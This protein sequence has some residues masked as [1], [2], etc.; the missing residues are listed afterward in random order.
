[1]KK[2]IHKAFTLIEVLISITILSIVMITILMVYVI[3]S[4]IAIKA[5][6]NRL[7]QENIKTAVEQIADDIRKNGITWVAINIPDTNCSS[8]WNM[9]WKYEK[10]NKLC[11]LKNEYYLAYKVW[12][13]WIRTTKASCSGIDTH[14]IIVKN[15]KPITN[16]L[17]S[18]KALSFWVSK[19]NVSKVTINMLMQPATRKWLK[20]DLI[21]ENK[22]IFQTTLSNRPF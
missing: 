2:S 19:E 12:V 14:C 17:V 22:L 20:P 11:T 9:E 10:W 13:N 16:S 18:I 3:A 21:K 15:G 4:D 5:D 8:S 1:M 7:M 6:I